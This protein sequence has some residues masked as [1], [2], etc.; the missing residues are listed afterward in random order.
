MNGFHA[1]GLKGW[2]TVEKSIA[3]ICISLFVQN[4]SQTIRLISRC[5]QGTNSF[6]NCSNCLQIVSH[7]VFICIL[8]SSTV[9]AGFIVVAIWCILC[10]PVWISIWRCCFVVCN[11]SAR[12]QCSKLRDKTVSCTLFVYVFIY[13]T[14]Y[15]RIHI[16]QFNTVHKFLEMSLYAVYVVIIFVAS[17]VHRVCIHIASHYT[18]HTMRVLWITCKVLSGCLLPTPTKHK[19]QKPRKLIQCVV[20][21]VYTQVVFVYFTHD[22]HGILNCLRDKISAAEIKFLESK[23]L[24]C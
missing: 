18:E 8:W 11:V 19:I 12:Q 3:C 15:R 17:T 24:R 2:L 4:V 20:H 23:H 22:I 1:S 7:Y 14:W 6:G 9:E 10:L 13:I 5:Q 21:T 16:R